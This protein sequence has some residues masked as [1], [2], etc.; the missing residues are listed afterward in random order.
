MNRNVYTYYIL[1][2]VSIK[3][4]YAAVWGVMSSCYTDIVG[5]IERS[6]IALV[7]GRPGRVNRGEMSLKELVFTLR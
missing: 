4:F 1:I 5:V 2:K 6:C 7:R 3:I